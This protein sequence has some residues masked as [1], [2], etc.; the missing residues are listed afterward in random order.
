MWPWRKRKPP[1]SGNGHAAKA[2]LAD[3]QRRL[4]EAAKRRGEVDKLASEMRRAL[5]VH[6]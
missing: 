3:A 4:A 5:G 1:A 2:A 6:R